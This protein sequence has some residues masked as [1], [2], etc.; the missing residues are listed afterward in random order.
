VIGY[1]WLG[2]GPGV[3]LIQGAFG[4]QQ[5]FSELANALA[6]RFTVY[7]P[8]RR[9]RGLSPRPYHPDY[10]LACDIEDLE[11][12]LA[13]TGARNVFGLSAGAIIGLW[14]AAWGAPIER[15]AAFEP[16]L[17]LDPDAANTALARFDAELSRDDLA[18]A[19]VTGMLA[20]QMTPPL[21]GRMPRFLLE[22]ATKAGLWFERKRGSGRYAPMRE[23]IPALRYDFAVVAEA[24]RD[25]SALGNLDCDV[26]LLGGER[27]PAY[28]TA[29]VDTV[30]GLVPQARRITIPGVGHG[31]AWNSDRQG[32]PQTLV[33]AL[34]G[35][36][37]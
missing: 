1:R 37:S 31:A 36:F 16:P 19:A 25:L 14:A 26:L 4:T 9:G 33:P 23:L 35:F 6:D 5:N 2:S 28:L 32:K 34:R 24:S 12:L 13:A 18:A 30:A 22:A 10:T 29:A 7:L 11:A 20:A 8:D 3:V 27:S 15:L 21:V 17:L